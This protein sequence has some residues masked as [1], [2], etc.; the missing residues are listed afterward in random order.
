MAQVAPQAVEMT[1][2]AKRTPSDGEK[3]QRV[4]GTSSSV[5]EYAHSGRG[6]AGNW[7]S[8]ANLTTAGAFTT[9]D[10]SAPPSSSASSKPRAP[11][12]VAQV[13]VAEQPSRI[14]GRGGAGNFVWE[15]EAEQK[16]KVDAIE[17]MYSIHDGVL[18]DVEEQLA[19]PG[20]ARLKADGLKD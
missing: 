10:K 9:T 6:G 16:A 1:D 5:D 3:E 12:S 11:R 20:K 2:H 15:T 17:K 13:P 8:P 18:R 4:A 19:R 7:F 14:T